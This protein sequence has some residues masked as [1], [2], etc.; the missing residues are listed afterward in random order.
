MDQLIEKY[1]KYRRCIIRTPKNP[2]GYNPRPLNDSQ[3]DAPL[4]QLQTFGEPRRVF[5]LAFASP[6]PVFL[7]PQRGA[8]VSFALGDGVTDPTRSVQV[9]RC[10]DMC[11]ADSPVNPARVR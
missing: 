5:E 8:L 9:P 4:T 2:G 1:E 11:Y 7:N 3:F 6:E 10:Q